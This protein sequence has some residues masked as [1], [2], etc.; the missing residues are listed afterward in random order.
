MQD[1]SVTI[2]SSLSVCKT[3]KDFNL[4]GN[5]YDLYRGTTYRQTSNSSKQTV[6]KMVQ[7]NSRVD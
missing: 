2:N 4:K 1:H 3:E 6:K 5:V 7:G